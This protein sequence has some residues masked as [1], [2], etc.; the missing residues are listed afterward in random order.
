M[1]NNAPDIGETYF[2]RG[3][4]FVVARIVPYTR[5]SNGVET[6]LIVWE[7]Q[8]GGVPILRGKTSMSRPRALSTVDF[9]LV[10][11]E[12]AHREKV[13]QQAYLESIELP[14]GALVN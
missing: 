8:V 5:K 12:E 7:L 2:Y 6:Q 1:T 10:P 4:E 9:E 13:W 14:E 11:L 3:H